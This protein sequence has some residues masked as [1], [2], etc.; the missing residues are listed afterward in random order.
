ML[1]NFNTY[2]INP[3][4]SENEVNLKEKK[5]LILKKYQYDFKNARN[6]IITAIILLII[7][8]WFIYT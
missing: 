4:K 7:L 8:P 3:N 6:I 1:Q 5:R 2:R